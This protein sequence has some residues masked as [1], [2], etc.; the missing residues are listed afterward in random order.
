MMSDGFGIEDVKTCRSAGNIDALAVIAYGQRMQA[1][2]FLV[3]EI[4]GL[5]RFVFQ[6]AEVEKAPIGKQTRRIRLFIYRKSTHLAQREAGKHL[7]FRENVP[8]PLIRNCHDHS[9]R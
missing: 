4:S 8:C 5:T 3:L 1:V 2:L 7:W 9:I 6:V